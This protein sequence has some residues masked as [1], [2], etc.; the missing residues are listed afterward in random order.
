MVSRTWRSLAAL[1]AVL[2]VGLPLVGA[3]IGNAAGEA[4]PALCTPDDPNREQGMQGNTRPSGAAWDCGVHQIGHLAGAGGAMAVAGT[5]A[6]TGGG[7]PEDYEHA[8][9][10][11]IDVSVPTNPQLV[12]V[13]DTGSR[14]LL[15]ARIVGDRG[16]LATRHRDTE[17]QE[18]QV[19]GR[20]MLI[21][22]WDI[23]ADCTNPIPKGTL[24]F[25]TTAPI[26]G[27]I[28][29]ELGG[30]GHN[31]ALNPTA[32]KLY[33]SLPVHEADITDL[34]D[35]SSWTVRDLHC[36]IA[37]QYHEPY[38]AVP[39]S[40]EAITSAGLPTGQG[41]QL[42]HE[43]VFR[44]DGDRL[45]IGGQTPAGTNSNN[46]WIV[47]MESGEPVVESVT[48][49]SPGHSIDYATIDGK[50]YLLHSNE[51]GG[52]A[53]VP[54]G[55]RPTLLGFGDRAWLL[56]ISDET[57][58][59]VRKSEIILEKSKFE[60]C[61]S[62]GNTGGPT[63]AYHDVDDPL[64]SSYAV[65]GFGPAGFR[66]FDIRDPEAPVEVAY[67]NHGSSSHTKPYIIPETGHIWV[68]D[69]RGFSVLELEPQVSQHLG[70]G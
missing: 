19:N 18:G 35:P 1:T 15:A 63:T 59:G 61:G 41:P 30:P 23:G 47:N 28:P 26:L 9:V 58:P 12:K 11:V 3:Q 2:G 56:D 62:G 29:G 10:R 32:T 49:D 52:T 70:L 27:D 22:V 6:Y 60:N 57:K 67:F 37:N 24:R 44:P 7:A 14:E 69:S 38:V 64:D 21:D 55:V 39:G 42:D 46:M 33:G 68:S 8:G 50:P 25:P 34:D 45:Y 31:L 48:P 4:S 65:I 16:V 51:I 13:L 40:C 20:D 43:P 17:A 53:C 36:M 54:E 66:F 5:C